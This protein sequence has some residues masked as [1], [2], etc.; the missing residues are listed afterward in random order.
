MHRYAICIK[1]W[2]EVPWYWSLKEEL[3][4]RGE[5]AEAGKRQGRILRALMICFLSFWHTTEFSEELSEAELHKL[6]SV[7]AVPC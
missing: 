6:V 7:H 3:R 2:P 5:V 4:S 1:A